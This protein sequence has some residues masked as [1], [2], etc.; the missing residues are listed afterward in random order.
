VVKP[1]R[2]DGTDSARN[3]ESRSLPGLFLAERYF[4]KHS[5]RACAVLIGVLLFPSLVYAR[6]LGVLIQPI[7]EGK[8]TSSL[9]YENLK[10]K[11]DFKTRGR[12]DSTAHVAGAQFTYGITDQIAVGFKGGTMIDPQIDAQGIQWQS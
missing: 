11:D 10:V 1:T 5:V 4:L 6:D 2:A 9:L 3:R 8:F 12:A 7:H